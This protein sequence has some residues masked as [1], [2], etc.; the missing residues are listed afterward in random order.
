MPRSAAPG[1]EVSAAV[2]RVLAGAEDVYTIRMLGRLVAS[3]TRAALVVD[4]LVRLGVVQTE[5]RGRARLWR[6]NREERLPAGR[7]RKAQ[8]RE[9][10]TANDR[11]PVDPSKRQPFPNWP[12]SVIRLT[13]AGSL[14][15]V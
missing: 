10:P 14:L 4:A 1:L 6:L 11:S 15:C 9:S 3:V 8:A 12:P 2:I 5:D 7:Q 13:G